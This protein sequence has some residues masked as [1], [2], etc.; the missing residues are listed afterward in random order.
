MKNDRHEK[1]LE[2]VARRE[3]STQDEL[4]N[5][6]RESGYNVTQATISRDIKQLRLVKTLSG[7]GKYIYTVEKSESN[8]LS[9]KFDT[10]LSESAIRID[11]VTN[12]VLIKCY[13]GLANAVCAALDT[14]HF[15][16]IV[17][18]LAGDDTILIIM[19]TQNDA[20]MLYRLL[21]SRFSG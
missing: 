3:I 12:Q 13:S 10:L 14:M 8:D 9:L 15:D 2:L 21:Q 18:T 16:G 4:L 17:G 19:R 20:E 5:M 6:L 11:Y 1:I 7:G